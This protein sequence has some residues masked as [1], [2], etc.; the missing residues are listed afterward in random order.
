MAARWVCLDVGETLI[1]ETR[2]WSIWADLLG[3]PRLTFMAAFGAVV[4]RDDALPDVGQEVRDFLAGRL[5]L[6]FRHGDRRRTGGCRRRLRLGLALE[7]IEQGHVASPGI[8][9]VRPAW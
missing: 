9:R 7:E 3:V 6:R 1:D 8:R 5:G 2:V 4:F